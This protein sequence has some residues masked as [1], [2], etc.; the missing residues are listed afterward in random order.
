MNAA[1]TLIG[2][3]SQIS[4]NI[5]IHICLYIPRWPLLFGFKQKFGMGV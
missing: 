2:F 1:H 5:I 4:F 3:F